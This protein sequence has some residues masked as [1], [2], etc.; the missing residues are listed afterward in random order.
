[1]PDLT[2][3]TA[4]TEQML[5]SQ[6]NTASLIGN[7][8]QR[9][10]RTIRAPGDLFARV[11]NQCDGILR[12]LLPPGEP[13][14]EYRNIVDATKE[15]QFPGKEFVLSSL[16]ASETDLLYVVHLF[17]LRSEDWLAEVTVLDDRDA[18]KQ[19]TLRQ[20]LLD[21]LHGLAREN[22]E[23]FPQAAH[24][25]TTFFSVGSALN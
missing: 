22:Y 13:I 17:G 14:E 5:A 12:Y 6:E 24:L 20:K 8:Q 19:E 18:R 7:S 1:M 15:V 11:T 10:V 9:F 25:T 2:R 21:L 23:Q 4:V 3:V 16:T